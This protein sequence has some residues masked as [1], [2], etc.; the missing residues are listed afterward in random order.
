[1]RKYDYAINSLK[2]KHNLSTG[3]VTLICILFLIIPPILGLPLILYWISTTQK[4]TDN[5]YTC[6]FICIAIY[7]AAI[8]ATKMPGGDQWQYWAAY[9]NVPKVGFIKSLT[10]IYGFD[11]NKETK[12]ISGEFMNGV[13]NYIGYYIT[14]GY[15]PLYAALLTFANYMLVFLGLYKFSQTLKKPHIPIVCGI[16]IL[17][18]FY[19]YFQYLLQ[20]QKQFLAQSIMMYVL[21]SYAVSGKMDKKEWIMTAC[22]IFTHA[23]TTLFLPFLL[24]KPLRN[25]LSKVELLCLGVLFS[26]LIIMGPQLAGNV[27][28]SMGDSALSY[29][30]N[31]LANSEIHND[32]EFG[33][34]WSQVF[35]IAFPMAWIVLHQLWMERKT[36]TQAHAFI[37]NVILLLLL[38]II[39]MF[40]QPLAQYRYFMMLLAFMPFV[41]PF[42]CQNTKHRDTILKIIAGVMI[43]WFYYQFDKII[44][45][46]APEIDII[47]KS[48]ILLLFG[49]YYTI[50]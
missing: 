4:H 30:A 41:Y 44:W 20:I 24:F 31:R 45:K 33:L 35:V 36:L 9:M 49:N 17:S 28:S 39:A 47:I 18:F 40:K 11:L 32:I 10:Y 14:F 48:P 12:G 38:T 15:Y 13:Y 29:G 3:E 50:Q 37:L 8:N 23:A 26:L 25:R 27:V 43:I 2:N 42:I 21:G 16:L 6:F 34:V 19:L 46:F 7:F 22:A 1:M 5:G